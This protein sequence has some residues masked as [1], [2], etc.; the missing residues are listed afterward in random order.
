[1]A[2]HRDLLKQGLPTAILNR[3]GEA[4][5]KISATEAKNKLGEVLDSV[6]Q[7][8]MVMITKHDTPKAVLLSMEEFAALSQAT[9]SRLDTLNDEFD[10]LLARMQTPKARAG[11]KAAFSASPK[12]LGK[13]ALA[14][15]RKR[16]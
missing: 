13:T 12:Q 8:G 16:G 3:R 14:A 5:A 9:R 11:R 1:M 10:A 2:M 15:A 6:L 7:S 4:P